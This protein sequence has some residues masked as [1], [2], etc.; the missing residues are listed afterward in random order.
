[1]TDR[2]EKILAARFKNRRAMAWMAFATVIVNNFLLFIAA[3]ISEQVSANLAALAVLLTTMSGMCTTI[4]IKYF[5][6]ARAEHK[7]NGIK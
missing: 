6:D 4:V 1:M 3:F 7:D 5:M 2:I